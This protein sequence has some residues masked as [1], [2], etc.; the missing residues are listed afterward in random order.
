MWFDPTITDVLRNILPGLGDF[1]LWVSELGGEIFYIALLL[2]GYWAFNKK[3]AILASYILI[4]AVVSN[5]WLK[6]M[7]AKDRPPSSYWLTSEPPPNYSTPS[8]HS[9]NSATLYGWFTARVKTWWMA[10]IAVILTVLVGIS[11]VY[12]GVH[13]IEDVLLGWGIG[14]ITVLLLI[15]M[16]KPAREYL[17]RYKAE[18]LL[19]LFAIIG[20]LMTLL[21][22]FL[23]QPPNDNFGA[24]GGLIIGFTLGI[25]LERRFVD[26]STQPYDGKRW[27]LVLRVV[28][29]LV[30]V[31]GVM[32]LL[33][34]ILPTDQIWLR[35][36]RY[37]LIALTGVFVWPFIFKRVKL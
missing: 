4:I 19:L 30:L 28:I 10:L 15:Y 27:R 32:V 2:I 18:H 33:A 29:G 25:I 3:E 22:S 12:I 26:F 24:Y 11:R 5:F 21:A 20:F 8:G 6:V 14:I 36:I 1:F 9:Q 31:I 35:T 34:P 37:G 13:Y 23:P 7:V 16:E 17:S